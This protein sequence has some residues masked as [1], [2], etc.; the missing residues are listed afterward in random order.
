[1][2]QSN[3]ARSSAPSRPLA[4]GRPLFGYG[5]VVI[6]C[7]LGGLNATVGKVVMVSGGL[8]PNRLAEFRA[9]ASAA[10]LL[11][12]IA[13]LAHG[14]FAPSRRDLPFIVLF[15]L[16][17]LALAQYSYFMS[18][19]RLDVGVALLIVNLAIV[20]VAV[21]GRVSGHEHVEPRLWAAIILALAGLAL[22]VEV[23]GGGE[24]DSLGVG[25][26]LVGALAYAVYI[27]MADRNARTGGRASVLVAWGF[28]F[29]SAFWAVAQPWWTF[30]FGLL[31]DDVSL[32]GRLAEYTAPVW[33]LLA[34]VVP[35]GTV[36]VFVLYAAALR[37]ISPTRVV[38]AAVLEP[39][40]GTLVAFAW[41]GETL[42]PVQLAGGVLVIAALVLAQSARERV[43]DEP[44]QSPA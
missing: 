27:L 26:A 23:W 9:T 35:F 30:P 6:A 14:R 12:G 16:F 2:V 21:W 37:Y 31:G 3:A 24:L 28:V 39:V 18:V 34:Y 22:V 20:L 10:I 19:E 7:A 11:A 15:G 1:M 36:G 32:L 40:F 44:P 8:S 43:P 41:L 38:I 42:A 13:L 17:G 29:A 25:A 5:L 4:R 33:L